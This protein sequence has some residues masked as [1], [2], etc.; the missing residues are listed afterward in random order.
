M[1]ARHALHFI[2]P[3]HRRD[4]VGVN[5]CFPNVSLQVDGSAANAYIQQH[6]RDLASYQRMVSEIV[7]G[8]LREVRVEEE[9]AAM[10]H[11]G[12]PVAL[13]TGTCRVILTVKPDGSVDRAQLAGCAAPEL[14]EAELEAV[15]RSSPLPPLGRGT[16]VSVTTVAPVAT[17]G[18]DGN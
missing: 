1:T 14:G 8:K 15:K 11:D 6:N 10:Q 17:P 3:S 16:I 5:Q 18:V 13:A 4:R 2:P 9:R 7:A 12:H